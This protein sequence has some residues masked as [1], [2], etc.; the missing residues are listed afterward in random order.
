MPACMRPLL[1][2]LAVYAPKPSFEYSVEKMADMRKVEGVRRSVSLCA[3]VSNG[4]GM[5][6]FSSGN[7]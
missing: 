3:S 2:R 6:Y 5:H 4:K 7:W 1:Y